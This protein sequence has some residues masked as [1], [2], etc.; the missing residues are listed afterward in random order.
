MKSLIH[1]LTG[2][3]T[4]RPTQ[5]AATI[6]PA[7]ARQAR[8][9]TFKLPLLAAVSWGLAALAVSA[10]TRPL[11]NLSANEFVE[12]LKG[13]VEAPAASTKSA[14]GSAVP[15]VAGQCKPEVTYAGTVT[16]TFVPA[17][18]YLTDNAVQV[19][20]KV[21]FE[22]NS[23]SLLPASRPLLDQLA[24]AL[25][26]PSLRDGRFIIAGH[27]DI[28]GSVQFNEALSCA[29]AISVRHYL[30]SRGVPAERL[31]LYGLG[32]R[33]LLPGLPSNDPLHR[34]VEVRRA[35]GA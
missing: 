24:Q 13:E 8:R 10:Q 3:S 17:L 2:S 32:S 4:P 16:R 31:G 21:Q 20:M 19:D 29:R 11:D 27:T 6:Q 7:L 34:R 12:R 30:I 25:L 26:S 5:L 15:G 18:E 1:T 33:M 9:R 28:T 23:A 35:P 14:F 22:I